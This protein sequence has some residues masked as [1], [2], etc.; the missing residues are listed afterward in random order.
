MYLVE[1]KPSQA[2]HG[3][4]KS[5]VVPNLDASGPFKVGI[6]AQAADT[7]ELTVDVRAYSV[8][9]FDKIVKAVERIV[10]VESQASGVLEEPTIEEIENAPPLQNSPELVGP[11]EEQFK[12]IY[13]SDA[14]DAMVPDMAIDDCSI[15]APEGITYTY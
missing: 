11:I 3:T 9:V 6:S 15:P 10:R 4:A 13:G 1:G 12:A 5:M 8:V 14:V 2:C 7:A